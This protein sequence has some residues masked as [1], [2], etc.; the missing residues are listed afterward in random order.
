[1]SIPVRNELEVSGFPRRGVLNGALAQTRND[2][3]SLLGVFVTAVGLALA[4]EIFPEAARTSLA[5]RVV[6][7]VAVVLGA[8]AAL[9]LVDVAQR[10]A[11]YLRRSGHT[12]RI[13][14]TELGH[15]LSFAIVPLSPGVPAPFPVT[16][17]IR[18]PD[19][20]YIQPLAHR[21]EPLIPRYP[22]GT[23]VHIVEQPYE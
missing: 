16:F 13:T 11:L 14:T 15:L 17:V 7:G 20:R 23:R 3:L 19:G 5:H 18:T 12:W 10:L 1:M 9:A 21:A 8:L 4:N 6:H 2:L 22:P